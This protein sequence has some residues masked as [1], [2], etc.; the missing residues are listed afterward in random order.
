MRASGCQASVTIRLAIPFDTH[1]DAR[2][3]GRLTL[4]V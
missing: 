3:P 4:E 1:C 2:R